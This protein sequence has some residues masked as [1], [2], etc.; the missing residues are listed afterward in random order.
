MSVS[1][2]SSRPLFVLTD[3]RRFLCLMSPRC[4][5]VEAVHMCVQRRRR[6]TFPDTCLYVQGQLLIGLTLLTVF[7]FSAHLTLKARSPSRNIT[8]LLP[9]EPISLIRAFPLRGVTPTLSFPRPFHLCSFV[10]S[11][12]LSFCFVCL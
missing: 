4:S 5:P 6:A 7:V 11:K 8:H 1:A 2:R 3:A 12:C 9:A 10:T